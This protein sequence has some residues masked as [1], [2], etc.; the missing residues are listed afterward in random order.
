MDQGD[1]KVYASLLVSGGYATWDWG[2]T[3]SGYVKLLPK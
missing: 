1:E 2:Y 3:A